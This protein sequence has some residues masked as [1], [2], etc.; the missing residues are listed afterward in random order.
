MARTSLDI[1]NSLSG[2][3]ILLKLMCRISSWLL[4]LA[5]VNKV[6][7]VI[8]NSPKYSQSGAHPSSRVMS[9]IFR[10]SCPIRPK[11]S[12]CWYHEDQTKKQARGFFPAE[13][14]TMETWPTT[15]NP[16]RLFS[17][18]IL[19]WQTFNYEAVSLY[20]LSRLGCKA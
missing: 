17:T 15:R 12:T 16:S 20:F 6:F 2:I 7:T 1:M 14:M 4:S 13:L 3:T 10:Q 5:K 11:F 9:T 18:E 8:I 19:Y